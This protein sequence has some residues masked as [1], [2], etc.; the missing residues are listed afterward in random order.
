[1]DPETVRTVHLMI[2]DDCGSG[3]KAARVETELYKRL[4]RVDSSN[5]QL[6]ADVENVQMGRDEYPVLLRGCD[7]D[8]NAQVID[9]RTYHAALSGSGVK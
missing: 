2:A 6:N 9:V 3:S 1:M 8:S 7:L 5:P 4:H